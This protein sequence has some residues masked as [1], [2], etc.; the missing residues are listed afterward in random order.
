MDR[1]GGAAS[2]ARFAVGRESK[3]DL[4]FA[5]ESRTGARTRV[6]DASTLRICSGVRVPMSRLSTPELVPWM[7]RSSMSRSRSASVQRPLQMLGSDAE[8]PFGFRSRRFGGGFGGFGGFGGGSGS[9]GKG[10]FSLHAL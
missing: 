8:T 2:F 4:R 5:R 7:V 3:G 10:V 6:M 9:P 1:G